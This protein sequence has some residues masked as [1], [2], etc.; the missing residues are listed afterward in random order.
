MI[1][2]AYL[3]SQKCSTGDYKLIFTKDYAD[4]PAETQRLID[5]LRGIVQDSMTACLSDWKIYRAVDLAMETPFSQTSIVL[6]NHLMGQRFAN[7][8][9]LRQAL[10]GYGFREGD[11]YRR[12]KVDGVEGLIPDPQVFTEVLLPIVR[13]N[14][15]MRLA[16]VFNDRNTDPLLEYKPLKESFRNQIACEIITDMVD[17]LATWFGYSATLRQGLLQMLS[18]GIAIA[19]PV[20]DWYEEKQEGY[21]GPVTVKEG[22][23]YY[24]PHP[25][26]MAYDLAYPL[27]SINTDSGVSWLMHWRVGTYG[28]ILDNPEFWNRERI[29]CGTNWMQY[30]GAT[31]FFK[32]VYPCTMA[33]PSGV[34]GL[35]K[36]EDKTAWYQTTSR[37]QALLRTEVFAKIKPKQYGLGNYDHPVWHRFSMASDDTV[38]LATP[39]P[40]CPAWFLGYDFDDNAAQTSSIALESIPFQHL[41]QNLLNTIVL[42]AKSN[43]EKI[44]FYDELAVDS[45]KIEVSRTARN[46]KYR[47]RLWIPYN[48]LKMATARVEMAHVF[49]QVTFAQGQSIVELLQTLP[50]VLTMMERLLQI[51]AQES[52]SA[53]PHQQGNKELGLLEGASTNR[54]RFT[55][56]YIDDGCDA[57]QKQLFDAI[58]AWRN[59]DIEAEIS[60]DVPGVDEV[61]SDLGFEKVAKGDGKYTLVVKGKKGSLRYEQFARSHKTPDPEKDKEMAQALMTAIQTIS[62]QPEIHKKLGMKKM[63]RLIEWATKLSGG[64]T[65]HL[66]DPSME[67][68]DEEEI[69]AAVQQAI[70]QAIQALAQTLEQKQ[71]MPIAKEMAQ[72][73]QRLDQIEPAVQQMMGIYQ[74]VSQ[75][76]DKNTMKA[77]EAQA[78]VA[79]DVQKAAAD[80]KLK[81]EKL[82][83]DLALEQAKVQADI[84][85]KHALTQADI[86]AEHMKAQAQVVIDAAVAKAKI[87]NQPENPT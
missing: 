60:A 57:W 11:L 15:M 50:I 32:E 48:K 86:E 72:D 2:L 14:T 20:E 66:Y 61:L 37:N 53:G 46:W 36:R 3:K 81:E 26:R 65:L 12:E 8:V 64:P 28:E 76:V 25:T 19:F 71:L 58:M 56:S 22:L 24:W 85:N 5:Y 34:T 63:C 45:A 1:D 29:F 51:S 10:D 27:S 4:L 78:K 74:K 21:N 82:Q 62:G 84:Q 47:N 39:L 87:D 9:E 83:H 69:P 52:G 55:C 70:Q 77:Q 73:K 18:Y 31:T 23:R 17:T 79:L 40:Y 59:D 35:W 67:G 80:Q 16:K 75:M 41:I 30:S 13:A 7:E 38:I 44:I 43:L 49:D 6:M 42:T 54:V 68:K 33:F